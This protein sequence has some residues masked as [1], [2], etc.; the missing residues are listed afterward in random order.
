MQTWQMQEAKA[1]LSELVKSA[2]LQ[3]QD[4]AIHGK[5]VAVIVSRETFDRLSQGQGTLLDFM[6][7]S[8]LFEAEDVV[9]ERDASLTRET[10]F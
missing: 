10:G 4:I 5:S 9:F 1:R 6:R 7:R 8:P 2:Q 3:P